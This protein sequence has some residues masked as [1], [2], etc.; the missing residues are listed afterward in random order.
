M[1]I[2]GEALV[3]SMGIPLLI[4]VCAGA[5]VLLPGLAVALDNRTGKPFFS[6]LLI[7]ISVCAVVAWG[8]S[9]L[10]VAAL[11]TL[12]TVVVQW[13]QRRKGSFFDG[14]VVSCAAAFVGLAGGLA[15]LY[16]IYREDIITVL[17]TWL[18]QT[19][20][21]MPAASGVDQVLSIMA[22]SNSVLSG[23]VGFPSGYFDELQQM[24][25]LSRSELMELVLPVLEDGFRL[26]M[27]SW[28]MSM[29]INGGLLG[30]TLPHLGL[31]HARRRSRAV[32]EKL[33]DVPSPPAFALWS[34]PRWIS[35][36]M[37]IMLVL[38]F[39]VRYAG[40]EP[41]LSVS[42]AIESLVMTAFMV[43]GMA[44]IWFWLGTRR[45]HTVG[46]VTVIALLYVMVRSLLS[47]IGLFDMIFGIRKFWALRQ[48]MMAEMRKQRNEQQ[49]PKEPDEKNEEDEDR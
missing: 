24:Q 48:Q 21:A 34:I 5:A 19:I 8:L 27:P 17:F 11:I 2:Q 29:A 38:A 15:V 22:A 45:I 20:S 43:Q 12:L 6:A 26:L 13:M 36:P 9:L 31:W 46:R 37:M 30:W 40:W 32:P 35:L 25:A 39:I 41:M 23:S 47:W 28:V 10:P 1:Q 16:V 18:S 49:K 4:M 3:L 44:V 14:L 33:K 7:L 42:L